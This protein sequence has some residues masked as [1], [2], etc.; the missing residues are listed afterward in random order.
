MRDRN[1]KERPDMLPWLVAGGCLSGLALLV[2]GAFGLIGWMVWSEKRARTAEE[3][4]SVPPPLVWTP[5]PIAP[6]QP[7]PLQP[8]PQA[9]AL[10]AT[11][12]PSPRRPDHKHVDIVPV[13]S[14][15]GHRRPV[16]SAA[17]SSD[18]HRVL[19]G[20]EDTTV[21]LW[22]LDTGKELAQLDGHTAAVRAVAFT[23][24][25]GRAVSAS[26]DGTLRLWDLAPKKTL[27]TFKGHR[28]GVL[29]AALTPDGKQLLS[30]GVDR[31]LRVWDVESGK[32]LQEW[33]GHEGPVN[34]VSVSPDGAYAL[35]GSDD[36]GALYRDLQTGREMC[37]LS[38]GRPVYIALF[39]PDGKRAVVGG[40]MQ[41]GLCDLATGE[42]FPTDCF[43][44]SPLRG[45]ALMPDGSVI[46]HGGDGKKLE[47][48]ILWNRQRVNP[49]P[50]NAFQLQLGV[51]EAHDGAIT[52]VLVSGDGRLVLTA[53][54]DGLV[55]LWRLT[56]RPDA[57]LP[58][59]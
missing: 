22:E 43:V 16:F 29:C 40:V 55:K 33:Y 19:S 24:D 54:S 50:V 35:T 30:G 31:S 21:R 5:P 53:G 47:S 25:G 7:G 26:Q 32:Q 10:K 9:P 27:R 34:C 46:L 56:E 13:R 59:N 6:G 17:L 11:P 28:G 12:G 14:Y 39:T 45:A 36:G 3:E 2:L 44:G 4:R 23:P 20:G 57:K 37:Y 8:L 41:T 18:G 42:Q 52:C 38:L 51:V 48:R 49:D 15:R 58:A 1:N